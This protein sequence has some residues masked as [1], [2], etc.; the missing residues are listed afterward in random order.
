MG[1]WELIS[2][3]LRLL[4][5]RLPRAAFTLQRTLLLAAASRGI[6]RVSRRMAYASAGATHLRQRRSPIRH[7]QWR[8]RDNS[9]SRR[10]GFS[11]AWRCSRSHACR[12]QLPLAD[13]STVVALR[14]ELSQHHVSGALP[15]VWKCALALRAIERNRSARRQLLMDECTY[16]VRSVRVPMARTRLRYAANH[17]ASASLVS[18]RDEILRRHRFRD[19]LRTRVRIAD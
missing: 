15:E 8:H 2:Q 1:L 14:D 5:H 16:C 7:S 9:S 3:G 4:R 17:G 18:S 19:H 11:A 6:R 13:N 12:P 10:A